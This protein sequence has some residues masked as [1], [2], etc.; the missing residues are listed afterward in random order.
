MKADT[1]CLFPSNDPLFKIYHDTEWGYPVSNDTRIFEKICLEGFQSGLSWQTILHRR[2]FFRVAFDQFN[3]DKVAKY[4][5]IDLC[6]L[7]ADS[8]IIRN[9]RK[10]VSAI[11]NA[12]RALELQSEFGSLAHF[13]WQYE[14]K[15]EKRPELVTRAWLAKNTMTEESTGLSHALKKRGWKFIGPT[16]MYALMQ[17]LGLV[18]DHTADCTCRDK[19]EKAREQ[20]SRP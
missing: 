4:S 17:A 14:P 5:E 15:D 11:N 12:N 19:V 7:L 13:I 10:I 6:R 9:R 1:G 20:F 3:I 2:E 16:N 18:N 8:N